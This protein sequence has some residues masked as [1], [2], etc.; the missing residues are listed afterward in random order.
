MRQRKVLLV[1]DDPDLVRAI[2]PALEEAG[3]A[4]F[5]TQY[6][7]QAVEYIGAETV[8]AVVLDVGL[9]D[10]DG[11]DVCQQIRA[12]LSSVPILFL[13]SRSSEIDRV[14]G[15]A[16]GADDYV[17]KPFSVR[18]LVFRVKAL[19]RR[20]EA[21]LASSGQQRQPEIVVS[22]L[23]VLPVQRR[24]FLREQELEL[25]ALE[26][27]ILLFF[28][29]N[30]GRPFSREQLMEQI[31]SINSSNFAA[32][33]TTQISRLRKKIEADPTNPKYLLTVYGIGYRFVD[34]AHDE[35]NA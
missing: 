28:V 12:T 30:L 24:A 15:F 3:F 11:F 1:E 32:S 22:E 2:R 6:G 29:Q 34:P 10:I 33:V 19:L 18:E 20:C 14:T 35:A 16:L 13:T 4:V 9:P 5:T 25:S 8:D 23:R 26:F 17:T 27:D 7:R 21:V 31:W